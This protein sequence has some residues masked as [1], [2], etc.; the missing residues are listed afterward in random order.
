M[1]SRALQ[2]SRAKGAWEAVLNLRIP[3][4]CSIGSMWIRVK[5]T[6]LSNRIT[7]SVVALTVSQS[8]HLISRTTPRPRRSLN[9]RTTRKSAHL[10]PRLLSHRREVVARASQVRSSHQQCCQ[11]HNHSRWLVVAE[12]SS[13]LRQLQQEVA[14]ITT[15][16]TMDLYT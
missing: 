15:P 14:V 6:S 9:S 5:H 1:Q 8:H 13:S 2:R 12:L 3:A 11:C 7:S 16:M 4:V 10:H